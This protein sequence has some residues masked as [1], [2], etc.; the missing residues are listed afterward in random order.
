MLALAGLVAYALLDVP[1][2]GVPP[3]VVALAYAPAPTLARPPLASHLAATRVTPAT[4]TPTASLVVKSPT[5]SVTASPTDTLTATPLPS[6]TTRPTRTR[7][8]RLPTASSTAAASSIAAAS[9]T[10]PPADTQTPVTPDTPPSTPTTANTPAPPT[11]THPAAPP[12][13]THTAVPPTAPPA[14]PAVPI[15]DFWGINGGPIDGNST[16]T[17]LDG[18]L[19]YNPTLRD[20]SFYWMNQ[21]GLRWFRN[22]GSDGINFSW[23]FVEPAPGVYDWS[24]W[25]SLVRAAQTRDITLLASIGNGVPQ[26]ANASPD[27]RAKPT[28]LYADPMQNTAW[29]QYFQHVVERYDGDGVNDMPGLTRPI[30]FWELWNEPDLREAWNSPSFPAH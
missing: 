9:V 6:A 2:P 16:T 21:A 11:V 23:R 13:V 22:Y 10:A 26:W 7:A 17:A 15:A 1:L 12:T 5:P 3:T 28:D 30:K 24:A 14:P 19:S 25:D 18:D 8:A 4:P 27:W 20:N 29:Y